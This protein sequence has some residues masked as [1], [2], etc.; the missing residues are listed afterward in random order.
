GSLVLRA[1]E[2]G[3]LRSRGVCEIRSTC[4]SIF[5]DPSVALVPTGA[6]Y[7]WAPGLTPAESLSFLQPS[8][9]HGRPV[10]VRSM[11]DC[12]LGSRDDRGCVGVG[13]DDET[14]PLIQGRDVIVGLHARLSH[15][16]NWVRVRVKRRRLGGWAAA[17][18]SSLES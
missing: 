18:M 8:R 7:D 14:W 16:D 13:V 4:D 12:M 10:V 6:G 1:L 9:L 5:V 11:V 15:G 17:V 2:A 3:L